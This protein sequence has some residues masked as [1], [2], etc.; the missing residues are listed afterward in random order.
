M[1]ERSMAAVLKTA[2]EQSTKGS[3]PFL[4]A[5]FELESL[6]FGHFMV[7]R[8]FIFPLLGGEFAKQMFVDLGYL[9]PMELFPKRHLSAF[10][11]LQCD[12]SQEDSIVQT[13][14]KQV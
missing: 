8:Q 2:V 10:E 13:N 14:R 4:S 7:I 6:P 3:N 5:K 11:R 12:A 1:A 9:F